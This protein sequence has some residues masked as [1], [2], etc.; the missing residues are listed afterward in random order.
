MDNQILK[1]EFR[2]GAKQ[3]VYVIVPLGHKQPSGR[4]EVKVQDAAT[5]E[6]GRG[7]R[8]LTAVTKHGKQNT[9]TQNQI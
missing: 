3:A 2:T 1:R 7:P 5:E 9:R 8:P 4:Q 6:H